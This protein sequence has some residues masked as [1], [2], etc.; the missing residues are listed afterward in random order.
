MT[1]KKPRKPR[2]A[3]T[4]ARMSRAAKAAKAARIDGTADRRIHSVDDPVKF[5]EPEFWRKP[6]LAMIDG[7]KIESKEDVDNFHEVL[8]EIYASQDTPPEYSKAGLAVLDEYDPLL[9]VY[10]AIIG[11]ASI[12]TDEVFTDK[13]IRRVFAALTSV[14]WSLRNLR[15]ESV[16]RR[17]AV[18]RESMR[19]KMRRMAVRERA[20]YA[21]DQDFDPYDL[22]DLTDPHN[23]DTIIEMYHVMKMH[24]NRSDG[25]REKTSKSMH[26]LRARYGSLMRTHHKVLTDYKGKK[27]A[28]RW[29]EKYLARQAANDKKRE[30]SNNAK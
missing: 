19:R 4:K 9:H 17:K 7:F 11:L 30:E 28:D 14:K 8:R 29:Q 6:A 23:L 21:V 26:I 13:D 15:K 27:H 18:H 12:T 20:L 22:G 25:Q 16:D 2:S 1:E 3:E 24:R 5:D 10:A